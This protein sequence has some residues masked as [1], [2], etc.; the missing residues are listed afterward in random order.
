[1]LRRLFNWPRSVQPIVT[2][3]VQAGP[4][5]KF[6]QH[7]ELLILLAERGSNT[8]GYTVELGIEHGNDYKWRVIHEA[9]KRRSGLRMGSAR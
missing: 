1:M 8:M 4:T 7:V 2:K 6:D 5:S 3:S 9:M